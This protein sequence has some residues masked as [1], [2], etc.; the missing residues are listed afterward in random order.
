M[1]CD[2]KLRGED[3]GYEGYVSKI[4]ECRI[5]TDLIFAR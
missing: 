2:W 5:V 1:S 3:D 4:N